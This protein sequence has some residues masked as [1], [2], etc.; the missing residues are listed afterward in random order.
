MSTT[1]QVVI[2]LIAVAVLVFFIGL[3]VRLILAWMKGSIKLRLTCPSVQ[4]GEPVQ[5]KVEVLAKKPI[6]GEKLV[7]AIYCERKTETRCDNKRDM[8]THEIYRQEVVLDGPRSYTP[9]ATVEFDLVLQTPVRVDEIAMA[10]AQQGGVGQVLNTGM[11]MLSGRER[12]VTFE[13][14]V[15]VRLYAQGVDLGTR[16]RVHI[17]FVRA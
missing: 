9:G 1:M 2:G 6:V 10:Q 14:W 8:D 13:W 4:G 5:G 12:H 17:N 7:A 16:E 3:F 11:Q 15:T